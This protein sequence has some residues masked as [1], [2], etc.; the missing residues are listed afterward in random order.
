MSADNLKAEGITNG[1][2][3]TGDVMLDSFLEFSKIALEKSKILERIGLKKGEFLFA[4]V[5][6]ARNTDN[7]VNLKAICEAFLSVDEKIVFS[8]HPRTVKYLKKYGLFDLL[9][10]SQNVKLIEPVSYLDSLMLTLNSKKVITD[11][12]GMQKEAYFGRVPC[13]TLDKITAWPETVED[14]WNI[15]VAS[16]GDNIIEAINH[17]EPTGKQRDIF[18]NGRASEKIASI[19]SGFEKHTLKT[20]DV[21]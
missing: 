13:V 2:Y 11:S 9:E 15:T 12:G 1:V 14:G 10:K 16:A 3:C 21:I 4:T 18:G 19:I 5:H 7:E 6:R 8:V 17:F 20:D